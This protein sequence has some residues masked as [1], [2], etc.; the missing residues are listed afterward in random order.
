MYPSS[1][2]SRDGQTH[3]G[4]VLSPSNTQQLM[5]VGNTERLLCFNGHGLT[6]GPAI[7]IKLEISCLDR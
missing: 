7:Q 5:H 2:I 1:G 3:S 4:R 6:K